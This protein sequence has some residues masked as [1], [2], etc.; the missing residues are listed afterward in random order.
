MA[1]SKALVSTRSVLGAHLYAGLFFA[2]LAFLLNSASLSAQDK[3]MVYGTVK[4]MGSAKKL[5]GVVVTVF[6]NG[7]K[8]TEVVT[9]ASGKYEV[10]LDYGADFKVMCSKP[11]FVGK[12]ISIDTRNVPEEERI[13]GHGMNIDFTMMVEIQGVDYSVLQQPFGMANYVKAS[14]NF[15]WDMEYTSRMRDA[16]ARL[17]KE[18]EERKKREASLE[19]DFAKQ[20]QAGDAAMKAADFKKAVAAYTAALDLKPKEPVATA[21]LSD[22]QMR[23]SE[24]DGS[25]KMAEE[26]A[27]LIKEADAQFTKKEYEGAK[28]KYEAALVLRDEV[29]PKNRLREIEAI[30][31]DLAKKAEDERLAKELQEKY[32]AAIAA[33][34]A[35]FKANGWDQA[36]AKY[37][38]ASD[39]KPGEKYPKD[40]LALIVK[41]KEEEAKRAADE[42]AQKELDAKYQAAIT[43]ADAAFN[44]GNWDAATAKYNEAAGVKPAEKYPKDQLAAIV[45]KKEEEAKRAADEAAQKELD[46]KYQAAI[47]A[48]DAAFNS[49]S[50]DAATAKYTEASGIKP[51]EKYPKDQMA[52]IVKKKEEEAKRAADE[53]AQKELD[54]KYQAAISAADGAFN[55]GEWDA[56]STKYTEAGGLKPSEKYP[57]DQLAAV[58]KK[59]EEEAKRA[60]DEAAQKDLDA[61]Y[62]SA[63]SAADAA[64]NDASWD[65]AAAKYTEA[66]GLK[67]SEKYP[68]D[69]LATIAKKKEEEAKRAADE[70]A[71]KELEAKYQAAITAADAAFN[72]GSWDAAAGKYTE[73]SSLKPAEKYPKDQLAA[74]AKN[75]EEEAKRAQDEAAAKDLEQRY[76][77]AISAADAA[78]NADRLE[79]A[80]AKYTD[81]SGIKPQESYPRDR[82]AEVEARMAQRAK[83][84]EDARKRDELEARYNTLIARADKAFDASNWSAA[85]ND[86][87]DALGVKPGEAHP[88]S[89]IAAIEKEM[90]A[91][92]QAKAEADRLAREK[93]DLDKRYADIIEAADRAFSG[94]DYATAEQGY[95]EALDLKA[96]ERHPQSRLDEIQRKRDEMAK[97]AADELAAAQREAEE[98]ARREAEERDAAQRAADEK[99]RREA[100]EREAA[101]RAAEERAR[102]EAEER[103]RREAEGAVEAQYGNLIAAADKLYSDQ[104]LE[105]ARSKYEEALGV[106]PG[107]KHPSDRIAAID[108][109]LERRRNAAL[110]AERDAEERRRADEERRRR[111]Q[112]EA[113]DARLAALRAKEAEEAERRRLAEAEAEARRAEEERQRQAR[114]AASALDERYRNTIT[115]ADEAFSALEYEEAR[116]LFAEALDLKPQETYPPTKI[117]QIDL[118][119]AEKQRQMEELEEK[120]RRDAER[121]EAARAR[122]SSTVDTRKEMEA[123]DFMRA[124]RE[125]E[126]AEKYERIR[127]FRS[128]LEAEQ[129]AKEQAAEERRNGSRTRNQQVERDVA[130]LYT[131]DDARRGRNADEIDAYRN[132]LEREES[133]RARQAGD[134]RSTSY[135]EKLSAERTEQDRART[136]ADRQTQQNREVERFATDV[137]RQEAERVNTAQERDRETHSAIMQQNQL[138]E[139]MVRAGNAS[140][141]AQR[142]KVEEEKQQEQARQAAA[143][144]NAAIEAQRRRVEEEKRQQQAREAA[145]ARASERQRSATKDELGAIPVNQPRDLADLNRSQL[146]MD[147]PPGVTEESLTEG[148]KVIIRRVVVNGNKADE[149]SK[150]IAKWGTFYFKNGHSISEAIWSQETER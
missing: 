89:R 26:Y 55:S 106:K 109:E 104:A 56:A 65:V 135:A 137:R 14:G 92:A 112:Q 52:A 145:L 84:A 117:A 125:R 119:L 91:A 68:K 64:F 102:L 51:S 37:T 126:E 100:E 62:Q 146:A 105:A 47:S 4:D 5:D 88:T 94:S 82:I 46:A 50:W 103:A 122:N 118:L 8:L 59:K 21:K 43:A 25:K 101:Q 34:D 123:E 39:L 114:E 80:K 30:L 136:A 15:E 116:G 76:N 139:A 31:A 150:V 110:A 41:K 45:K 134:V 141:E 9:N 90:D 148:N 40:Q 149:Y 16:Q 99:A 38:E 86:Y 42:A 69:Q 124:A 3:V 63:I 121:R 133:E 115:R 73:A 142:R 75:K 95:R 6:K 140:I 53:A 44:S 12:N 78:F 71:Q 11:G 132:A 28:T 81:A 85:L 70:A 57:K 83:D 33:A 72:S 35:A 138:D 93:Q 143:P 60:A 144:G 17:L 96:G 113:E 27:A 29:H 22:A 58:A 24:Q 2:F 54:A 120:A 79:E 108:A 127:K 23:L 10:Y 97:Q 20:M 61:R 7:A 77:S 36:T 130:G 74:I 87:K 19:A 49:G 18:Y 128:D 32:Q 107:Q 131:G 1:S 48:A 111:E 66:G 98:R 67:P 129:L 147:Y 13:G